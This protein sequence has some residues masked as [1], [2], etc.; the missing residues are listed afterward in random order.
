MTLAFVSQ[1]MT[2]WSWKQWFYGGEMD[3]KFVGP[4]R[5]DDR[6]TVTGNVIEKDEQFRT[7][8][9]KLNVQNQKEESIIVGTTLL[10]FN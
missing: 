9:I 3:I 7:A 5:P 6:V 1:M 2:R 8:R 4:V 10:E